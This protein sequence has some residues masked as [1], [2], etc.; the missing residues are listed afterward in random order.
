MFLVIKEMYKE[1]KAYLAGR[2]LSSFTEAEQI[3][4]CRKKAELANLA[5]AEYEKTKSDP[6]HALE[7][8]ELFMIAYDL[9]LSKA[10]REI[11]LNISRDSSSSP[12][13]MLDKSESPDLL[14]MK[15]ICYL[16]G[17]GAH[18]QSY[19]VAGKFIV[20][21]AVRDHAYAA[22][23]MVHAQSNERNAMV[24]CRKAAVQGNAIA[25]H[26]LG[27]MYEEGR[28]VE[29]NDAEALSWCRKAAEQG[30]PVAQFNLG[31][32]YG[33]GGGR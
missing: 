9:S 8:A 33:G 25:Q 12:S 14:F 10:A 15:G 28:G 27:V 2:P 6:D 19:E 30:Y 29:K 3:A 21:A 4:Y 11:Q 5:Y 31:V 18:E 1:L 26:N 23:F 13:F 22:L 16:L 17:I 24:W 32:M 20:A 7:A